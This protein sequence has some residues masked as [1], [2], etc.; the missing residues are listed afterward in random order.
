MIATALGTPRPEGHPWKTVKVKRQTGT[1]EA[2]QKAVHGSFLSSSVDSQ[3]NETK[4]CI[5]EGKA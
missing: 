3:W 4:A 2:R 1:W 5:L